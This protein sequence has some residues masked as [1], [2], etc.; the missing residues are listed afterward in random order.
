VTAVSDRLIIDLK[1]SLG[2]ARITTETTAIC[3]GPD[4]LTIVTVLPDHGVSVE[5]TSTFIGHQGVDTHVAHLVLGAPGEDTQIHTTDH[6]HERLDPTY[7]PRGCTY[8]HIQILLEHLKRLGHDAAID[9][10]DGA[11]NELER[12]E[13]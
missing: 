3:A 1:V 8:E 10:P 4:V 6:P 5:L 2:G 7:D 11:F 12:V 13:P 9:V